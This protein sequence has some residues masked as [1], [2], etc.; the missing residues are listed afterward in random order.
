[1]A[2]RHNWRD[3]NRNGR[4][5][6]YEDPSAPLDVRVED[7]LGQMTLAEK[8]GQM[9]H[10]IAVVRAADIPGLPSPADLISDRAMSHFNVMGT[11]PARRMA[12]WH[13]ALQ[14]AAAATR[15]GIPVTL[16]T[17][18]RHGVADNPGTAMAAGDFSQWPEPLGLAATRDPAVVERFG[19]IARREYR[20]VGISVA[21]HPMADLATE[22]RWARI[23]GTFGEDADLAADLVAAYIRGFQ[24][25]ALGP[26]SVACMTKHFPGG[27]PQKDGEDPHFNYGRE[28]VYP[29]NNFAFH[30]KPFEAALAAGTAQVMP[31]YGMPVGTEP[32][33]VGFGFNRGVVTGLLRDR[34]GFDG[35]VCA[36]WGLLTDSH[37][38]G[39][40]L[41]ARAWGVEHLTLEERT[42]QAIEAGVDQFGGEDR[43]EVIVALVESRQVPESRIDES[44]R[45]LLRD[46]FRLGLFD[47][48]FVDPDAAREIVGHA[49]FRAAGAEA[50]RRSVVLLTNGVVDGRAA[51]PAATGKRLYVENI[52]PEV[53]GLYGEVVADVADADLAILRLAAPYEPRDDRPLEAFFH[54]GDLTFTEPELA[55]ILSILDAAPAVVDIYLD[56]PAVIPE[57][58]AKAVALLGTFGVSDEVVLDAVF[59]RFTPSGT[60]P[61]ELPSSM[62]AVRAQLPD[63]PFDS[64]DPV[65]PF[66]HKLSY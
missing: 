53:A 42:K 17:D 49:D 11:A 51:L 62:E 32:E 45:R 63:V 5:D 1:M 58:A 16:S 44:V 57:I 46:K 48:P 15:L 33:E 39:R 10:S 64:A 54:A 34:F 8:A 9:M 3:L 24:G 41:E 19:E 38:F 65:F 61:V 7:L 30:L 4:L 52:A 56:R 13:N 43:P 59:G 36:D 50:Q 37:I 22:P 47:E 14:E 23:G 55:R 25:E 29:G 40:V 6:P 31:S 26:T 12:E 18:P 66:G 35:V 27:G 28:Q 2:S 60:L 20:A 21:L